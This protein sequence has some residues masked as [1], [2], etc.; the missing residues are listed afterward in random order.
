MTSATYTTVVLPLAW[1]AVFIF[2]VGL[3]VINASLLLCA[4]NAILAERRHAASA[5]QAPAG[6][7]KKG[8]AK[9]STTLSRATAFLHK[10]FEVRRRVASH[11]ALCN[12]SPTDA[13]N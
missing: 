3:I 6:A 8:T 1:A 13:F 12:T 4:R 9:G 5:R 7:T 2:P 11:P 10:E